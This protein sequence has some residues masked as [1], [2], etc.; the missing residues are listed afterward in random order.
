MQQSIP[1]VFAINNDYV[2]QLATVLLSISMQSSEVFNFNV[3]HTDITEE[4]KQTLLKLE[5]NFL[6]ININFIDL[7]E[8]IKNYQ[9]NKYMSRR[10]NYNYISVETYFRFFIPDLFPEYEKVLYLDSDIIVLDDLK[11]LYSENIDNCY[12]GVVQDTALEVFLLYPEIKTK[13]EPVCSYTDYLKNK[14]QKKDLRYFNAGVLLLNLRKMRK[15][16]ITEKLLDFTENYA[17]LEFQDQDA[18]NAILDGNV[19]F[20][21]Y[22]WNTLCNLKTFADKISDKARERQMHTAYKTPAIFHYVG[23][24]KPWQLN[25]PKYSYKY[26]KEWW[27]YFQMT[28]FFNKKQLIILHKIQFLYVLNSVN[29]LFKCIFEISK[30]MGQK[31]I[32]ILGIKFRL[33]PEHK[34]SEKRLK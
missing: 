27:K 16:R 22:R 32:K 9:L 2:K 12:A 1:I 25:S 4:N 20:L 30:E 11:K 3:L 18:L 24:N 23:S 34:N 10:E 6:N 5:E 19:K 13:T 28:P 29:N 31:Y 15:E 33:N 8:F 14:L 17:P 21:D 26:I 7:K